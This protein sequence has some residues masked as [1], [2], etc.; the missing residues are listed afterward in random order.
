MKL[1]L[2]NQL[3]APDYKERQFLRFYDVWLFN[4]SSSEN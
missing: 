4:D 3:F 1:T 2:T